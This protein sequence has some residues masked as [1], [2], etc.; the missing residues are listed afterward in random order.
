MLIIEDVA[1]LEGEVCGISTLALASGVADLATRCPG[2]DRTP[3][4]LVRSTSGWPV[5]PYSTAQGGMPVWGWDGTTKR[6]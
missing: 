3:H 6:Q 2:A 5:L 1:A 4:C